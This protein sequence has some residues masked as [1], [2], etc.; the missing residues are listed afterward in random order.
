MLSVKSIA[1]RPAPELD[2]SNTVELDELL[3]LMGD[4]TRLRI[5]LAGLDGPACVSDIA[6][7]LGLSASLAS[8]YL[9]PLRRHIFSVGDDR[10]SRSTIRCWTI[11]SAACPMT[12]SIT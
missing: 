9:R 1:Q 12:W 3:G 6:E 5:I 4:P 11:T 7:R 8:H 2:E 10:Q